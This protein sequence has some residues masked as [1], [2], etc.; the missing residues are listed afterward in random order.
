VRG[1]AGRIKVEGGL[2][3]ATS[4]LHLKHQG[5]QKVTAD[6]DLKVSFIST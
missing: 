2:I 1:C 6:L 5:R 3:G 4:A